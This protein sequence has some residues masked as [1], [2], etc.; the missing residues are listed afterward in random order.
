MAF[1]TWFST[2]SFLISSHF[3]SAIENFPSHF[4]NAVG[5]LLVGLV[6]RTHLQGL[7]LVDDELPVLADADPEAVGRTR[8]RPLE[9]QAG[10]E[11]A[12]PVARAFEFVFRRQPARRAAQ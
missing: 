2:I 5:V 8:R 12:A 11:K 9:I 3:F 6:P 1:Q 10:L 7:A 4:Q